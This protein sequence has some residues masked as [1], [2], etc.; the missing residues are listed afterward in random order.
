MAERQKREW[1]FSAVPPESDHKQAGAKDEKARAPSVSLPSVSLPKGGGAI[2]GID[3]KLNVNQATG[4][5]SLSVGVFT[6][7]GRSGFGPSLGLTY[8]SGAGNGP[9]GLGWSVSVPQVTRKTSKGLPLYD[10]ANDSDVFILS[11]AEELLPLRVDGQLLPRQPRLVGGR[12]FYVSTYRPR[13]ESGFARIER[14]QDA[15]SGSVHWRTISRENVTSL[16]GQDP[17]SRIADPQDATRIFTWLLDL[18]FDDRG[19][20]VSYVYKPEDDVGV[21]FAANEANRVVT[22]NRYLKRVRYGNRMPYTGVLPTED[23]WCFE[24]VLD[25]GE[26]ELTAPTPDDTQKPWICREDAFSTYRSCFEVRT[27]R[28]CR[29]LLMF[30]SFAIDQAS[31]S[32]PVR[33]TDLTYAAA[34]AD[35]SLPAYSLL[36][37]V[38]QTGWA[39]DAGGG[40]TTSSLPPLELGYEPLAIDETLHFADEP[41]VH[42]LTGSEAR[43]IDV[44]GEGLKGLLTEDEGAWYYKR[45]VSAWDPEGGS[46]RARLE[47][48]VVL[49]EKPSLPGLTLTDLN[50]DGNLCA[51]KL[52]PPDPGW[53]EHVPDVG[54]SPYRQLKTTASVDWAS[55]E[56]RIV[57]VTGDGLA[58]LLICEDDAF[59]WHEWIVDSG[60]TEATRIPKPFDEER[61]PALIFAD[62]E[63]CIFLADMSGDGLT[64]L[65]RIRCSEVCYWPNLGYGRFGTKVAMDQ[66]PA[67]DYADRFDAR[68]V[69]LA[70]I[71]GS[72][73]ADLFY[74]GEETTIWFNQSGGSWTAPQ[75]LAQAPL[76]DRD[77]EVEVLD[78]L[79]TGTACLVWSSTLPADAQR[80]LRYMDL[81]GSQKPFLLTTV[82]N[83]F[84]AQRTITYAPS[85]KF[86]LQDLAAEKPWLTR[87][88]FPVHVVERVDT[89]DAVSG[90][91]YTSSYS[92]H[93]GYYDGVEREFRGFARVDA[94]D[95]DAL[96]SASGTGGFTSTP[97]VS[98]DEFTLPAVL[99]RTWF[100]TGAYFGWGDIAAHL[101]LEYWALD[102]EAPQLAPTVLPD[103]TGPED[104][105]EAARALRGRLLREEVYALD[106]TDTAVNPYVTR[107]HRYEVD[108]L[109]PSTAAE[110][111]SFYAW[112][113]EMISCAYE[114]NPSD[115]RIAHTL[116]LAIDE[117]GEVTQQVTVGY[118]R[119]AAAASSPQGATRVH[120]VQSDFAQIADPTLDPDIHRVGVPVET[121]AYELTG[122]SV[123]PGARYDPTKLRPAAAAAAKAV[124]P[125]EATPGEGPQCRMLSR[126]RT[127]YRSN[128]LSKT[129]AL[130]Q[131]ESLALVDATYTQRYTPGL[132]ESVYRADLDASLLSGA[133]ALVDLDGD[134]SWWAPSVK[135]FYSG[136]ATSPNVAEAAASFYLPRGSI[137]PWGNESTVLYDR[138]R[139]L[140]VSSKDAVGNVTNVQNNYR[141]LAPWLSTD[142]NLNRSGLRYNALGMVTAT[143]VMGKRLSDGTDEGDTLDTSTEEPSAND[144]PTK[145]FVYSLGAYK[146][147]AAQPAPRA[148]HP[149]PVNIQTLA[150]IQHK[151]PNWLR[152]YAYMDG[153]GR[154]ALTKAQAEAGPAPQWAADGTLVKNHQTQ[155]LELAPT[156][157]RWVGSGR[158]VYDNKGNPV[159][160]YEPFFDSN[161]DYV[162]EAELVEWGVTAVTRRD[163][164]GRVIRVD[165]PDGTLSEV[166]FDAWQSAAYDENDTVLKSAWYKARSAGA[167][168][169]A[170]LDAAQK[171]SVDNDT[172]ATTA[173]DPLGRTC[174]STL[175][176]G[177]AG[178]YTTAFTL[179]ID[180]NQLVVTDALGRAALTRTYDMAGAELY[181]SS[182]DAGERRVLLD[183]GG[184]P[185]Q[186]WDSRGFVATMDYDALRR[187]TKLFVALAADPS[188][189]RLAE[190]VTYGETLGFGPLQAPARNLCGVAYQHY[191]QAGIASTDRRDFQGNAL[192]ISRELLAN[193]AYDKEIDW[194]QS[195][196][197]PEKYTATA[198]YDAL[199][200]PVTA[201]TPDGS[202]T[203]TTFNERG[204]IAA[205]EVA[206]RGAAETAFVT[207]VSYDAKGQRESITYGNGAS[208]THTYDP[209]NY[210]LTELLSARRGSPNFLQSLAYA[211]DPVGNIVSIADSAQQTNF[212]RNQVVPASSAYTY[213]AI[214]RLVNASGREHIGQTSSTPVDADDAERTS[215]T[216]PL[217]NDAQAMRK[218][219]ETYAYEAVGNITN[220]THTA[221]GGGWSR[222]YNYSPSSNQLASTI[223]AGTTEPYSYDAH[224]NVKSMPHLP[225]M[226]WDW[227]DQL[228]ATATQVVNEGTPETTYYR[229]DGAGQRIVKATYN[230]TG[231]IVSRRVYLGAY[232]LYREYLPGEAVS[233]E[234]EA[235]SVSDGKQR[236]SLVETVTVDT[237]SAAG[238][239]QTQLLRYQLGNH[240]GSAVVELDGS[241]AILSYEE[242]YPYGSTSFR[243]GTSIAEVGLKRYRYTGKERDSE[244]GFYYHGARYYAPWLGRWTSTDPARLVDGTNVYEYVGSNPCGFKDPSGRD[245]EPTQRERE[246]NARRQTS[247]NEEDLRRA[248]NMSK[249]APPH[250]GRG[251]SHVAS[252]GNRPHGGAGT[253]SARDGA[254]GGRTSVA[255]THPATAGGGGEGRGSST[256]HGG[257]G[258]GSGSNPTRLNELDYAVMFASLLA[259]IRGDEHAPSVSGGIPGGRGSHPSQVLQGVYIAVNL[260]F[261]FAGE[262]VESGLRKAG[263]AIKSGLSSLWERVGGAVKEAIMA[264]AFMFMGAGGIGGGRISRSVL[265]ANR[266]IARREAIKDAL[267]SLRAG[268]P[269]P[270]AA[271]LAERIEL[272]YGRESLVR[273]METGKLPKG[274]EFSHLFSASEYPE[275]SQRGDLGVLTDHDEHILDHHD[276]DTSVPLHGFPRRTGQ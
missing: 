180:G 255:P 53:F 174:E 135:L 143:A 70:D 185:I 152:S 276:N 154:I 192:S 74:L 246:T 130:G 99:T 159:K 113:L 233:L 42:N 84:G 214:Y 161:P 17:T 186:A 265:N 147:W 240:L 5:T 217:A 183:A 138:F 202:I 171:A 83:N 102:P 218:Y 220:I 241:A 24:V 272:V 35:P 75:L 46:P 205:V 215:F 77:V 264:P 105:R 273:F 25:Y 72:G 168:G 162:V 119:R 260:A 100:H 66:S 256:V 28:R 148:D 115:P 223:V 33:S 40:Y 173:L 95:T 101:Q 231:T 11:G 271:H 190:Q 96:P 60:F 4:T 91:K 211:Y 108:L 44:N 79:G 232:E 3:E 153:L 258:K 20:A 196:Q 87:L 208:T 62:P 114:R 65:V 209:D 206:V 234:R 13:V 165:K 251:G 228:Q 85:T 30:H 128:D 47:P 268:F 68:R 131:I 193:T 82:T 248:V 90:T 155:A 137:D 9:F 29:R 266:A 141:V 144:S 184:Q 199:N 97:T 109:Q 250:P 235:L 236:I 245:R 92:Y 120:Y 59:S 252:G 145:E 239:P 107:E 124:I 156:E 269:T 204:L 45:N 80:P 37:S 134:G 181:S 94:T 63:A 61:G 27:Y 163:P 249:P 117:W 189:K 88:P 160:A 103:G 126:K 132:L 149:T 197:M 56:L 71:D 257:V 55:P 34:A 275:W 106:G 31:T 36:T 22:A 225:S 15:A 81:T 26:H 244:N 69:R 230:Q 51:V 212:Y 6:S 242:Y 129:L 41:S 177:A 254:A 226:Q 201:T 216:L 10:D 111:G 207:A 166:E 182:I 274:V 179:D 243:A 213:D 123:A 110:Y 2:K 67:F 229:Y 203:T 18:S 139:L 263:A 98:G 142:S 219:N 23:E 237:S 125:Y 222:A 14:W 7:P 259:P 136:S 112:E 178:S 157:S 169:A 227:K 104:L 247:L 194:S 73:T 58:D 48:L 121:R 116:T 170:Q 167:L 50:G 262:A 238:S 1:W 118:A 32:V 172:P 140:P 198:T 89:T 253:N 21:A 93:H 12:K 270:Q 16:Y 43:W 38:T 200:R 150:R 57:D 261:T 158:V 19:N 188:K 151:Q 267:E 133:A 64:D 86:Y 224:G 195:Q 176:N 52:A 8:D 191:D 175:D 221:A 127:Y 76:S 146:Q 39:P 49:A 187:P 164:L 54:W 210:R 122:F 78:L